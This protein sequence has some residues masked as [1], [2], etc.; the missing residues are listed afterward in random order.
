[1]TRCPYPHQIVKDEHRT[2]SLNQKK[3]ERL[4]LKQESKDAESMDTANAPNIPADEEKNTV[5]RYFANECRNSSNQNSEM[6]RTSSESANQNS[7]S[8]S[9]EMV[10]RIIVVRKPMVGS[11]PSFIPIGCVQADKI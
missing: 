10:E 5:N 9:T 11:L 1:M 8:T 6:S 7:D 3:H 2:S 4:K